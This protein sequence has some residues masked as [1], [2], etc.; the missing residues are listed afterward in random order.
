MITGLGTA[1]ALTCLTKIYWLFTCIFLKILWRQSHGYK[2]GR[3]WFKQGYF[4]RILMWRF[5][6][7]VL[8]PYIK[9][10]WFDNIWVISGYRLNVTLW[11]WIHGL[12][13][14]AMFN[15]ERGNCW[16][17]YVSS[18]SRNIHYSWHYTTHI[19]CLI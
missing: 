14:E 5:Y 9:C 16:G 6:L 7:N 12:N 2:C 15:R 17:R 19:T 3:D 4:L 13:M 10:I 8:Y 18:A 11:S 1:Q